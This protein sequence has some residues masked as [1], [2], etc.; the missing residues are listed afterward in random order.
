MVE[1]RGVCRVLVGKHKENRLLGRPRRKWENNIKTDL[2]KNST[3]G[4][5]MS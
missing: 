5:G 2:E 4:R 3:R 1:E